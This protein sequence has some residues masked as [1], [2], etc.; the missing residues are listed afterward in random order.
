MFDGVVKTAPGYSGGTTKNP[1]Y[2]E[3]CAGDTG[4]AEVLRIEY[5][6]EITPL[7]KILDIFFKMHDPTSL[8]KQGNDKGAQYRSAIFYTTERQKEEIGKFIKMLQKNTAKP[9]VTEVKKLKAFYPAE[10]YH[11]DYFKKNP[12]NPYCMFVIRPKVNKIKKEFGV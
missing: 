9:I 3:V 1:T 4:H 11:K 6:P 2:E 7:G 5:N 8:N 10:D 12:A